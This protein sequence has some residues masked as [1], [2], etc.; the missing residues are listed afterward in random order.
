MLVTLERSRLQYSSYGTNPLMGD[1]DGAT[2]VSK[3]SNEQ[4][5]SGLRSHVGRLGREAARRRSEATA[6]GGVTAAVG[7]SAAGLS[8]S[9]GSPHSAP[10]SS[11]VAAEQT[12]R[13]FSRAFSSPPGAST[14]CSETGRAPTA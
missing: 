5:G 11:T 4:R 12:A 6:T 7:E 13:A 10:V 1:G 8:S 14:S 3:N 2:Q 9:H